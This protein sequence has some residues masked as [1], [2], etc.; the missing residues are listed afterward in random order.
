MMTPSPVCND[1]KNRFAYANQTGDGVRRLWILLLT[2]GTLFASGSLYAGEEFVYDPKGR[3][4]PFLPLVTAQ[5]RDAA[6]LMGIESGDDIAIEGI[7]Y[8]PKGSMV[9]V[10]GSVM[11][12]GEESGNLKV[13]SIDPKGVVFAVN[14]IEEYKPLYREEKTDES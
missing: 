4:D 3:R 2:F 5:S 1:S 13:V 12:E 14:G 10:N 11:K 6:G 8:D 9:I 7:V